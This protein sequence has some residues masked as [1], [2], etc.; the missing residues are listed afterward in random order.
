MRCISIHPEVHADRRGDFDVLTTWEM[1]VHLH[2]V[3]TL[4]NWS[5]EDSPLAA[6]GGAATDL[7]GCRCRRW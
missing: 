4:Q 6:R 1:R 2:P 7:E 5:Q 3:F